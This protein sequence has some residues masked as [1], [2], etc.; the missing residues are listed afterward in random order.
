MIE[1]TLSSRHRIRNW[2]PGGLRPSTLP[3]NNTQS[4]VSSPTSSTSVQQCINVIQMFCVCWVSFRSTCSID[5]MLLFLLLFWLGLLLAGAC[6][7]QIT[8]W[9]SQSPRMS[10][11][12]VCD[13]QVERKRMILQNRAHFY[14]QWF[15]QKRCC[16]WAWL[17]VSQVGHR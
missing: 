3:L 15:N 6:R 11:V 8:F 4:N 10:V 9:A 2:S 14:L 16:S 1:M 5:H 17:S 12:W 13:T 7:R